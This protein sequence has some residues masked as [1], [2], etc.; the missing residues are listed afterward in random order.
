MKNH[1]AS[2]MVMT[3]AELGAKGLNAT[4]VYFTGSDAEVKQRKVR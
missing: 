1:G 4:A 2:P 3:S